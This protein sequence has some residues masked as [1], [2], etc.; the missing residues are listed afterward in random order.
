M[1]SDLKT[2]A[3]IG[4][5]INVET[6]IVFSATFALL[7]GFFWYQCYYPHRSRDSLSPVCGIIFFIIGKQI[8]EDNTKTNCFFCSFLN[9]NFFQYSHQYL[10]IALSG[11]SGGW[12]SIYTSICGASSLMI[13]VCQN[14]SRYN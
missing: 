1:V 12:W 13:L 11:R 3:H 5:K 10:S 8:L 14:R 4:C 9:L 2:F 6:K 7:A